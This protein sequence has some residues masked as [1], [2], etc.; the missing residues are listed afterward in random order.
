MATDDK[1]VGKMVP[2]ESTSGLI[3][4]G[5]G[6]Q[7]FIPTAHFR[8]VGSAIGTIPRLQQ[9]WMDQ[10]SNG[11]RGEWR[12]VPMIFEQYP[13]QIGSTCPYP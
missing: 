6:A 1:H 7:V 2:V 3:A 9:L 10:E 11:T 12:E 8:R 5:K 4:I 13:G